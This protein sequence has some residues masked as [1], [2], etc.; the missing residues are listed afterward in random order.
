MFTFFAWT[1]ECKQENSY[2]SYLSVFHYRRPWPRKI[3]SHSDRANS[4][5]SNSTHLHCVALADQATSELHCITSILYSSAN[6][7]PIVIFKDSLRRRSHLVGQLFDIFTFTTF[8]RLHHWWWD[9]YYQWASHKMSESKNDPQ[10][11]I[12]KIEQIVVFN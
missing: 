11:S 1:E 6:D 8:R 12:E 9:H 2:C 3:H 4:P 5:R 10:N 7:H